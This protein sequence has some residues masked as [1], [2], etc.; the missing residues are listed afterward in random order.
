MK[1]A[2]SI[3]WTLEMNATL[4]RLRDAGRTWLEIGVEMGMSQET[5]KNHAAAI[6]MD[7]RRLNQIPAPIAQG[8]RVQ[9]ITREPLPPGHP[10]SWGILNA[11]TTLDGS[12]YPHPVRTD[13][14]TSKIGPNSATGRAI[15]GAA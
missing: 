5:V 1:A 11:G 3:E 12:S 9:H 15:L 14:H 4:Q 13:L 7:T 6:G 10:V 2:R 8:E